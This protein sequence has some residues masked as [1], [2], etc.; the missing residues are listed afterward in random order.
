VG[1]E[2]RQRQKA[3]RAQRQAEEIKAARTDAVKRNA[4]RWLLVLL[5]AIAGVVLIAWIGGA[6]DGDDDDS[7][8]STVPITLPEI[9]VATSVPSDTK[10]GSTVPGSTISDSTISDSTVA[11]TLPATDVTTVAP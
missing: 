1:T 11:A 6:F 7:P 5:L 2:K 4:L 3:N 10:P 9:S 8:T